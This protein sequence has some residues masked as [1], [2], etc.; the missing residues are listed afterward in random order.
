[1]ATGARSNLWFMLLL[2]PSGHLVA[3]LMPAP[4][5]CSTL[6]AYRRCNGLHTTP[7]ACPWM[8]ARSTLKAP[9]NGRAS[10]C[11][12]CS[13]FGNGKRCDQAA[14]PILDRLQRWCRAPDDV[15]EMVE[16]CDNFANGET[17]EIDLVDQVDQ[18]SARHRPRS[19]TAPP[20]NI[21]PAY[22]RSIQIKKK[23]GNRSRLPGVFMSWL[24]G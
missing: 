12:A 15:A 14:R 8:L 23:P 11:V 16:L 13:G 5:L 7:F 1:V 22:Q 24:R 10:R 19:A 9:R 3:P 6:S 17:Q 4:W 21:R 2:P 20:G 18:E